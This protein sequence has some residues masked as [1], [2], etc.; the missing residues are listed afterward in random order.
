MHLYNL[1]V[2]HGTLVSHV[3]HGNFSGPAP[4]GGRPHTE[5]V[6]AR[7]KT[8]ELY[9]CDPQTGRLHSMICSQVFGIVR[10]MLSFRLVGGTKDYLVL[11]SDSGRIAVLEF[12]PTKV[13]FDKVHMETFGKS[14][15]RRIIPG[16]VFIKIYKFK[17][18]TISK[19]YNN[20]LQNLLSPNRAI[21]GC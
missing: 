7:N 18:F 2:Q 13:T 16:M 6:V 19:A 15:S 14:G 9:R 8:I 3:A 10:S 12:N 11:G 5:I 17:R 1:T 21:F 20:K 4:G